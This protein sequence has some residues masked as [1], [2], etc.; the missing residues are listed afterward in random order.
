[1][2]TQ[3]GAL[4]NS[5]LVRRYVGHVEM[6]AIGELPVA[7]DGLALGHQNHPCWL[8]GDRTHVNDPVFVEGIGRR[9]Q[10]SHRATDR[11]YFFAGNTGIGLN[12]G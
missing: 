8:G 12:A 5:P 3:E 6:W 1:M 11:C 9:D 7:V 4:G 2:A 10:T